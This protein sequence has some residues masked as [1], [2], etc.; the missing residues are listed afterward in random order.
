VAGSTTIVR[1]RAVARPLARESA[2]SS[3]SAF[4]T[5]GILLLAAAALALRLH[6]I[7]NPSLWLD[8][9][10]TLLFSGMPLRKLLVV[11]GAHEH[12]PLYYLIVHAA[13]RIHEN[14]LIPRYVSAVCGALSLLALYALGARVHSR[15]AGFVAAVLLAIAPFHVWF[16][17]DGRDYE[18]AGLVVLLSYYCLFTAMDRPR[19][20]TWAAY[21]VTTALCLYTEYTTAFALAAQLVLVFRARD[22]G[23]VQPLLLSWA[24]AVALFLPWAGVVAGDAASIAGNYWIPAP[25]VNAVAMTVLEFLG[26]ATSC[27]AQPCAGTEAGVPLLAGHEE[28]L[29]GVAIL[30]AGA[31]GVLAA[32]R[33][34]LVVGMLVAWL[35][36]A[37]GLLLVVS[38]AQSLFLDRV[39]LVDTF[40]LYLLLGI[41]V[42]NVRGR[43]GTGLVCAVIALAIAA[44]SLATLRPVFASNLNPDWK[45]AMRD[46]SAAYRPGQ[47]AVFD[48]GA[49]R[50]LDAAYLPAGWRAT[51]DR[52]FWSRVYVDVPGWQSAYPPLVNPTLPQRQAVET[53][54]RNRQLAWASTGTSG[55][56]LVTEAYPGIT[57]V[58]RW[59]ATHGF[60]LIMGMEYHL[61][62]RIEY[63]SRQGPAAFGTPVARLLDGKWR[64]SPLT[65]SSR[66]VLHERAGGAVRRSFPVS[67]GQTFSISVAYRGTPP[68][69]PQIGVLLYDSAGRQ[70]GSYP[71]DDWYD[72]PADGVWLRNPFGFVTPPGAVRA[73]LYVGTRGGASE[74]RNIAIYRER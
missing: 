64:R 42:A 14:Y 72:L 71:S 70:I 45:S 63:W 13:R 26:M 48:P 5:A 59:F 32:F 24:A 25:S 7:A 35:L 47:G 12:P 34:R 40:P 15:S 43:P 65:T 56:W 41:G 54:L 67:P 27:S 52:P 10:Y 66:G 61:A 22:R 30:A 50:S 38:L 4:W 51:R 19:F 28:L 31:V 20:A 9:G 6:G 33:R 17:R 36:G 8:E 21:A 46:L 18:L 60:Q 23:L 49:L 11:G 44:A 1:T 2:L 3:T 69:R 53:E 62:S 16:S 39:V 29:A 55:T 68:A 58:R 73:T 74:W 37:F 57:D